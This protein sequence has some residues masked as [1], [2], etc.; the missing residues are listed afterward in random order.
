MKR[1]TTLST[2]LALT[3]MTTTAFAQG[4]PDK[5]LER[6]DLNEDGQIGL[7]E[8]QLVHSEL[9]SSADSDGDGFLTVE[10]LQAAKAAE[11]QERLAQHFD[12]LDSDADGVLT[13]AEMP[14]QGSGR[15]AGITHL[16]SDGDGVVT[17][18]EFQAVPR[19]RPH[20]LP[21]DRLDNDGDGMISEAEFINNVPLFERLDTDEDGVITAEELAAQPKPPKR[22]RRG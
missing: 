3:M 13:E 2:V 20:S 16:D 6:F 7:D 9:F 14:T 10:E 17:L 21:L 15:K 19:G 18:E 4:N 5:L 22:G 1:F 8:V 12:E 11:Q